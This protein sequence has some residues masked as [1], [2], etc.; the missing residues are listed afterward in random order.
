MALGTV[1]YLADHQVVTYAER[2]LHTRSRDGEHLEDVGPDDQS[3][4]HGE[5]DGI[6]PFA[7]R[8]FFGS[9]GRERVLVFVVFG[10]DGEENERQKGGH[11]FL[12]YLESAEALAQ[13]YEHEQQHED[14]DV[15][16]DDEEPPPEFLLFA[17]D[18]QHDIDVVIGDEAII[19]FL[20]S[21]L[22]LFPAESKGD[23]KEGRDD[24][25]EQ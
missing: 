23:G 25:N 1:M 19:A 20:S 6:E 7:G 9:F 5:D 18:F 10:D 17:D 22:K 4:D 15:G 11:A 13:F 16:E 8:R 2:L 21:G 14:V 24:K 12:P 3:S